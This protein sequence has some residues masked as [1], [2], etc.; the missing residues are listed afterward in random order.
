MSQSPAAASQE[1]ALAFTIHPYY[2][3]VE[4]YLDLDAFARRTGGDAAR[5]GAACG[6]VVQAMRAE[7]AKTIVVWLPH[8]LPPDFLA[9]ECVHI[10]TETLEHAG[11][12]LSV[13]CDEALAYLVGHLYRVLAPVVRPRTRR[14]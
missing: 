9:H 12:P 3:A 14:D 13:A 4:V 11:V 2:R 1:P 7:T 5:I 6:A 8:R 10:A